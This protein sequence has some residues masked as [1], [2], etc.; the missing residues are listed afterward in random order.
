MP[1]SLDLG[2]IDGFVTEQELS[3]AAADII[4]A[5][6]LLLSRSGAGSEAT[7]W[8]NPDILMPE[9]ELIR[10]SDCA[11][12]LIAESDVVLAVGIGGS[13]LGARAAV[14]FL[15]SPLYNLLPKNTPDIWFLGNDLSASHIHETLTLCEGKRISLIVVSKSGGTIE[16][17]VAF[18][19]LRRY[20]ERRYG[21]MAAARIIAVTDPYSGSLRAMAEAEG[22][23][24]FSIPRSVGGRYS[25]LTPAGLLAIAT[26]GIDIEKL[27]RGA[28]DARDRLTKQEF[29]ENTAMQYAAARLALY[30]KGYAVE[31][32][33]GWDP[34]QLQLL[35]WLK[36]L[37]GESEGKSH[38]G[39]FPAAAVYTTD[40]HSLGQFVQD[41]SRILFETMLAV[42]K[43]NRKVTVGSMDRNPDGLGYLQELSFGEMTRRTRTAVT[44]AHA[45]GGVPVIGLSALNRTAWEYG[46]MLMFFMFSCALSGYALGIN[47]FDQPGVEDYKR[48]MAALLG[49][50]GLED[51]AAKLSV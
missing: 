4:E 18:R 27:L 7:G 34:C 30:R 40:L 1:L 25:V 6:N 20:M 44:A 28:C 39:L 17:A 16:T 41:G 5:R 9:E 43:D 33:C 23:Q 50:P 48:N 8:L 19:V 35:E 3:D 37:F 11:A 49:K 10:I 29:G 24:T 51:L 47:P 42:E 36:Q 14:E 32:F 22:Y 13:Y 31:L 46:G 2:R 21:D 12:H 38:A 26:A 45:D 15:T